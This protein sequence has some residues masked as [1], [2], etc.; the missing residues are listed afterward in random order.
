MMQEVKVSEA[1]AIATLEI[2]FWIARLTCSHEGVELV[3]MVSGAKHCRRC[4]GEV[5]AAR[6]EAEL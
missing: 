2:A 4:L 6:G 3:K 1:N 5:E